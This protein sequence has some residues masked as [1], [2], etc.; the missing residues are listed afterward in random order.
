MKKVL[1]FYIGLFSSL[2]VFASA[3]ANEFIPCKKKAVAVLEY[4]LADDGKQCWK[5]S[6]LS[7]DKCRKKL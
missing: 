6:K 4:C 7:F 3:T 5:K 1:I 2:S